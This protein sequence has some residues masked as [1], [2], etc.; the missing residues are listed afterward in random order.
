MEVAAGNL[1]VDLNIKTNDEFGR[2]A[3]AFEKMASDIKNSTTSIEN[4]NR[5]INERKKAEEEIKKS[6]AT[7]KKIIDS[8]PF[9]IAIIDKNK[10]IRMANDKAIQMTGRTD[11]S[12]LLGQICHNFICPAE[13]GN[14]PVLDKCQC[15]DMS[16]KV[17]LT[18]DHTKVQ[19]LKSVIPITF[20]NEEVLL[21]AFVDITRR[22]QAEEKVIE[23]N[24]NLERANDELKNFAYIASHDLREPLR[25][26]TA[27]G[28]IL[29]KSIGH[30]LNAD[31]AENLEFMIDG[32]NR[33][34]QMI[35]GLLSYSRVNTQAHKLQ[36][37]DLEQ[38]VSELK[39][40]ELGLLIEDTKTILK[41]P[42]LLP[43]VVADPLQMRQLLQNII[44]N[45]IKYQKKGNIPEITI[46]SK[47]SANGMVRIEI[48]DNGIGIAPE[49]C[50]TIFTMFKRLHNSAAYEGTG[51]GLAVC[52]KIVQQ[53]NGQIGVE[54]QLGKGSTFWFTVPAA[55]V[56]SC[57]AVS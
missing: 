31:D 3:A 9:G 34:T 17:L 57:A 1:D 27:F 15:V 38:T 14:C 2:L 21:E 42:E 39:K 7:L 51:I 29:Q 52:K 41:V 48:T 26:I 33:M 13:I 4:L 32:A 44:V 12:E 45:A 28:A 53:H 10:K 16:E 56:L 25:K 47:P 49:Y 19:I 23:L 5:E 40:Y 35:N 6:R 54:S 8:M 18:K 22:K 50:E 36:N 46:T 11:G 43:T 37:V 24:K 30:T 55:K 20:E